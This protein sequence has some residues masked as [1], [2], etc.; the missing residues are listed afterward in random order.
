MSTGQ[1]LGIVFGILGTLS[2]IIILLLLVGLRVVKNRDFFI[3]ERLGKYYKTWTSGLH[4][5]L[6]IFDKIVEKNT[7]KEKV[8]DF[9]KQDV[10]TKDNVV[11]EID[12]VVY[13]EIFDPK[14]FTYGAEQPMY[15]VRNLTATTLRNIIGN[16]ELDETLTSR[17]IINEKLRDVLD[18]A[19]DKWGMKVLRVEL[20]NILPPKDI[21]NAMEK[22]M[23]A[24]REKRER[25]L[26]AEGIKQSEITKAEGFKIATILKAEAKKQ[27]IILEAEAKNKYMQL[28]NSSV[29]N[30][31]TILLQSLETLK[32]I[33]NGSNN[34]LI[35]PS[36]ITKV[37]SLASIFNEALKSNARTTKTTKE[38]GDSK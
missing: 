17:D 20:Q 6:L 23:R 13:L 10:I 21:R 33:A 27:E 28:L 9:P 8:L 25:I 3:I 37:T 32:K 19:T 11:M 4:W 5:K 24:E 2:A 36:E 31:K 29:P 30:D 7:F 15:A 35:L 22:Q 38:K 1:I 26:E 18:E 34:T 12:T 14:L 16:M